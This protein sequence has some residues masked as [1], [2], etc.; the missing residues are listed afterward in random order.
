MAIGLSVHLVRS[1]LVLD[2]LMCLSVNHAALE[3][4]AVNTMQPSRRD[5]VT[6]AFSAS[7][8]RQ[9]LNLQMMS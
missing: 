8:G 6:L 9:L 1:A 2:L 4:T 3:S 7:K 5:H